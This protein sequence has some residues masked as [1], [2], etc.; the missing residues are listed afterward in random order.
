MT[1]EASL[2]LAKS[3][4]RGSKASGSAA[5]GMMVSTCARSPTTARARLARSLVV[6]TTRKVC[7][8]AADDTRNVAIML[9]SAV[10]RANFVRATCGLRTRS[11]AGNEHA[12]GQQAVHAL[13][14]AGRGRRDTTVH[15]DAGQSVGVEP[16]QL[17]LLLQEVDHGHRRAVH[18]L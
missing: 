9:T 16:A 10:R 1:T 2:S 5:G 6:A 18:G 13:F 7:A 17:A 12:L 15:G 3:E 8:E 11:P 14:V 4:G